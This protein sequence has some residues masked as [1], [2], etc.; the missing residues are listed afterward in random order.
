MFRIIVCFLLLPL[1]AWAGEDQKLPGFLLN[2]Q[3]DLSRV[4]GYDITLKLAKK[5]AVSVGAVIYISPAEIRELQN[6]GEVQAQLAHQLAHITLHHGAPQQRNIVEKR[7][8]KVGEYA[9]GLAVG[10]AAVLASGHDVIDHY[11]RPPPGYQENPFP[12]Q[13]TVRQNRV[14]IIYA[15]DTNLGR[16]LEAD[17]QTL[18]IIKQAGGQQ[19]CYL[20]FLRRQ[21][22]KAT[23]PRVKSHF[24]NMAGDWKR[25]QTLENHVE[26]NSK[27]APSAKNNAAFEKF[28]L[29]LASRQVGPPDL[30]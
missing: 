30:R 20:E 27:C 11:H 15:R 22:E 28:K 26:G 14:K 5:P 4:A 6:Y 17:E 13:D 18:K 25:L 7:K 10:T 12:A 21:Y 3:N 2:I 16:E 24:A 19:A 8:I 23:D 1:G 9:L 29:S